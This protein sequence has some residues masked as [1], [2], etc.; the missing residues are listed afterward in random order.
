[1][2]WD[3]RFSRQID[4][5]LCTP[6][7]SS[8]KKGNLEE[9][10]E[11]NRNCDKIERFFVRTKVS[12]TWKTIK[13]ITKERK[14]AKTV[15]LIRKEDWQERYIALLRGETKQFKIEIEEIGLS[16]IWIQKK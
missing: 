10:N 14:E 8:E 13:T 4:M 15:K 6:Q 3:Q 11:K 16:E 2:A 9:K 7:Q 5:H 1:M 12:Q